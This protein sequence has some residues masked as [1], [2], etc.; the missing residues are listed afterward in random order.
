MLDKI[1]G[2]RESA[3][4]IR[5]LLDGWPMASQEPKCEAA[6]SHCSAVIREET[7]T[8]DNDVAPGGQNFKGRD[9]WRGAV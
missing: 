8:L 4:T 9:G 7:V 5:W 2:M 1:A 3:K 6:T